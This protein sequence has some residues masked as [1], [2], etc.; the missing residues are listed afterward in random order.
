MFT[1]DKTVVPKESAWFGSEAIVDAVE[2][3]SVL[4]G[5]IV[6]QA[7]RG[8]WFRCGNSRCTSRIGLDYGSWT[9]GEE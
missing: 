1:E 4:L 9:S 6:S 2:S 5:N 7:P 8:Q 3:I